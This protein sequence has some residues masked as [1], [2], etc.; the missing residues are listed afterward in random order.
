MLTDYTNTPDD[1]E[2]ETRTPTNRFTRP[3]NVRVY[4]FRHFGLPKPSTPGQGLE[5]QFSD[6]ESD[7]LPLDDPGI[8][9]MNPAR[10]ERAASTSAGSRS[11][12][13]S[14]GS[15]GKGEGGKMRGE[16]KTVH[17]SSLVLSRAGDEI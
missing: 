4:Q 9:P 10:F 8:L 5:P 6:P 2:G 17:P 12:P 3:S 7:V 13:L 1:A 15:E 14:Y 11:D 16:V